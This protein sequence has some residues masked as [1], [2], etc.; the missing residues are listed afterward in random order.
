MHPQGSISRADA[1]KGTVSGFTGAA[2]LVT[3]LAASLG[4]CACAPKAAAAPETVIQAVAAENFYG[5]VL[6]EIGGPYVRVVDILS[7]PNTDP[8]SYEPTIADASMVASADVVVQNG[9]G[10]DAFMDKLEAA[11]PK[12][13]RTVLRV[14]PLLGLRPGDNW[15]VWYRT[16]VMPLMARKIAD[17]L[18]ARD[19]GQAATFQENVTRFDTSLQPWLRDMAQVRQK[20]QGAPVAVTEPVFNYAADGMGLRILTPVSFQR[21]I[22]EGNDPTLQDVETM[23]AL[24]KDHRVRVFLYNQQTIEPTT[25]ELL[26]EARA[27]G[28]PVVGV[29]ETMPR[30]MTYATWMVTETQA[31]AAALEHGRSTEALR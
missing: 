16:D 19:P 10:Y 6:H 20:E 14:G 31:V 30:E 1:A 3:V 28:I 11:S 26:R 8:H 17:I 5:E 4:L 15:H 25:T 7:N 29:Y 22:E 9:L 12:G 13:G 24:F 18:A 23:R 2:F 21:A 27:D